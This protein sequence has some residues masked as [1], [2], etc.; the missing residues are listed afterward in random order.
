MHF[1]KNK[2]TNAFDVKK[3][4]GAHRRVTVQKLSIQLYSSLNHHKYICIYIYS[5]RAL[6]IYNLYF[7]WCFDGGNDDDGVGNN[8][9]KS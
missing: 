9:V 4:C 6:T 5:V 1:F 8:G 7:K 3:K 2:I